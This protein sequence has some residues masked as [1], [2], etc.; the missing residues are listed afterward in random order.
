MFDRFITLSQHFLGMQWNGCQ[1]R[2]E[3]A[4]VVGRKR[5]EHAILRSGVT[6][7]PA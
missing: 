6:C 4:V 2:D 7:N 5:S 3:T 1:V